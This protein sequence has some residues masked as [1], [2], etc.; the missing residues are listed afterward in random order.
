[1]TVISLSPVMIT[2]YTPKQFLRSGTVETWLIRSQTGQ[3]T[4]QPQV[5][6][7]YLQEKIKV[8]YEN[9]IQVILNQCF[10]SFQNTFVQQ[11]TSFIEKILYKEEQHIL[12]LS[13]LLRTQTIHLCWC[14]LCWI[15]VGRWLIKVT[16]LQFNLDSW[17]PVKPEGSQVS[18]S[19]GQERVQRSSFTDSDMFL[20]KSARVQACPTEE[21]VKVWGRTLTFWALYT[22]L[23]EV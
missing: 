1:M 10:F 16:A 6:Q 4:W 17:F 11:A 20:I 2:V 5:S 22:H 8:S 23:L 18:S 21:S 9:K 14:S 19:R 12:C 3:K 15:T 7:T 13:V